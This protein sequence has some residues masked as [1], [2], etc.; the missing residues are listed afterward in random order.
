[1]KTSTRTLLVL[2]SVLFA[3]LLLSSS[4]GYSQLKKGQ[5]KRVAELATKYQQWIF[6]VELLLSTEEFEAF[7]ELEKDYQ[8][9]AFIRRFW[10]IRDPYPETG[11]NELKD[12]WQELLA[13]IN[14]EFGGPGDERSRYLLQNGVPD[15]RLA[16]DCHNK[17]NDLDILFYDGSSRVPFKFYLIFYRPGGLARHRLWF[18]DDGIEELFNTFS[19]AASGQTSLREIQRSCQEGEAVATAVAWVRGQDSGYSTIIS[20]ID[21]PPQT[22]KGEWLATF[23]SYSTELPEEATLFSAELA[24]DFPGRQKNRTVFQAALKIP[25]GEAGKGKLGNHE[26]YNFLI[27]G[28]ILRDGELFETFR[29]KFDFPAAELREETLPLIFQRP[30]RPGTYK[31]VVKVEDINGDRFYREER[32]LEVPK[33]DTELPPPEPEDPVTAFLLREAQAA[34]SNGETTI[35]LLEPPG[36]LH[37]GMMRLDTLTTGEAFHKVTFFLDE[38]PVLSKRRPPYSVELDLGSLPRTRKLRVVGF[39]AAGEELATDEILVNGGTQRFSVQLI[40]PRRG[41]S[42]AQSLLAEAEL[43]SPDDQAVERVEFY[44]NETLLATL[45]QPPYQQP[46]VLPAGDAIAYVR[47]VAYLTDGSSTEDLVFV[48]APDYLE[49]V[50]V[51]FVEL[52]TS[53]LDRQGHPVEGLLREDFTVFEDGVRQEIAR[54]EQVRNLPFHAGILLDVSASMGESLDTVR[55]AALGFFQQTLSPKDRG[56]LITFN[57][58]PN[59]AVKFTNDVDE[60]AGGLAGLK[61]ERGTSLYDSVIFGLYYFNGIRGQ[62]ALLLL[63][64]GK[65]ESSRFDFEDTLEYARRAGVTIYSIGLKEAAKDAAARRKLSRLAEETGG[66]SFFVRDPEE[67][68]AVYETIQQELRSQYLVAY[69]SSSTSSSGTFREVE[70][71]VSRPGVETKTLS[72]YYP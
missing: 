32:D 12:R 45:Y 7:M 57:D 26:S 43:S 5:K 17:L 69:Q 30:L 50:D 13:Y 58:R 51:Q 34:I 54:F 25:V 20:R 65:D 9:D 70:L 4:P 72:G 47:A 63:S 60:L 59:L 23:K 64:D 2:F 53:A 3:L 49:E 62:K 27:N 37:T 35:R 24:V 55:D 18:P 61:A 68:K 71:K 46:V 29:Y 14:L 1:M 44:W 36:D 16:T 66:R 38:K 6:E 28:E 39:D 40:E 33:L 10:E 8:R 41:K 31:I 11:R 56:S 21:R 52:F 19:A 67:L 22:P 15:A 48:N 42:Y